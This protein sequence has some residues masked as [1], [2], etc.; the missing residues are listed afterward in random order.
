MGL[1]I[2]LDF[3][4]DWLTETEMDFPMGISTDSLMD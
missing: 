4:T 3:Q 2:G 1:V